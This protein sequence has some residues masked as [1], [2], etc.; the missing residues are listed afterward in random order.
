MENLFVYGALKDPEFQKKIFGRAVQGVPDVLPGY[1]RSSI[2]VNG[3]TYPVA[4]P[5]EK[6]EMDGLVIMIGPD[7]M[8]H[9]EAFEETTYEKKR[10]TL[11]SGRQA[12]VYVA[13]EQVLEAFSKFF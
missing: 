1:V 9:I 13:S 6:G 2:E 12:W 3:N 5:N 8:A 10:V 7:E 4:M 11:K